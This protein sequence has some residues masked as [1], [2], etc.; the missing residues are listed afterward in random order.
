MKPFQPFVIHCILRWEMKANK[1]SVQSKKLLTVF[2]N[3][4]KILLFK[5]HVE[6]QTY[7]LRK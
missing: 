5:S 6:N 3:R 2:D 4:E 7:L 1:Y